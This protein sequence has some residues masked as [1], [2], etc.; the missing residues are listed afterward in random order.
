MCDQAEKQRLYKEIWQRVKGVYC[1]G[2]CVSERGLQ[3]ALYAE[4]RKERASDIH[5]VVEPIWDTGNREV[6]K[7]DLVIVEREKITDIFE[8]KFVPHHYARWA[9]DIEKLFRYVKKC[10]ERYPV[11]LD[12][13]TGQWE[14]SLL[15]Q[16]GCLLHFVVVA[17]HDAKAIWPDDLKKEVRKW[18]TDNEKWNHWFGRTGTDD[19]EW[20]IEFACH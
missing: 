19:G 15:V 20:G 1:K 8:L 6:A 16:D 4:L 7:P 10:G 5:V 2:F 17:R 12:P 3:A 13:K 11:C 14:D 18:N 9:R